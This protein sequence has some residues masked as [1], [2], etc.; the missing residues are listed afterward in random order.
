MHAEMKKSN[1]TFKSR[2]VSYE[3]NK[4]VMEES[5]EI[6]EISTNVVMINARR[7]QLFVR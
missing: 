1:K 6:V 4:K 3:E 7:N 5:Y 2:E